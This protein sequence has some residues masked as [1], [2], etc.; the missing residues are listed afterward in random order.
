MSKD[1][2]EFKPVSLVDLQASSKIIDGN[3]RELD[4]KLEAKRLKDEQAKLKAQQAKLKPKP[5]V[6]VVPKVDPAPKIESED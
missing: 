2:P 5:E 1:T 6:K 3:Q 4:M